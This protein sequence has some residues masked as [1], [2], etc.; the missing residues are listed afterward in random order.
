MEG[1]NSGERDNMRFFFGDRDCECR[2][3]HCP[4][5]VLISTIKY[6]TNMR[7]K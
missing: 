7:L 3:G 2:Y 5:I 4:F 1:Q 6:T